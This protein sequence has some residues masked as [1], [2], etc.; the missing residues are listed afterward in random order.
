MPAVH[1]EIVASL[2]DDDVVRGDGMAGGVDAVGRVAV[3]GR[4]AVGDGKDGRV[5]FSVADSVH[6]A[7]ETVWGGTVVGA[8]H[9]QAAAAAVTSQYIFPEAWPRYWPRLSDASAS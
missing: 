8:V 1:Q 5:F 2:L 3:H 6:S 9:R 7:A 4:R